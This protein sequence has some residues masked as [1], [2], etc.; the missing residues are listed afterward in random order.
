MKIPLYFDEKDPKWILLSKV[1][2]IFDSRKTHQELAK[3]GLIPLNRSLNVL[4]I[5][6]IALFFNLDVSYVVSE[7]YRNNELQKQLGIVEVFSSEQI[8]EFLSRYDEEYWYEFVIKLLNRV[9]FKNTRGIRTIIV[10]GTDIQ[11]D[12]NWLGRRISK[13]SLEKKPYKWGLFKLKRILYRIKINI[14][15]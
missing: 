7:F 2:K 14:S 1:L 6:M 9:N 13:K 11:I 8:S 15:D 10:D 4:K 3:N 5:V 12:L